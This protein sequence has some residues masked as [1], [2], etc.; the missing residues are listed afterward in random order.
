[1]NAE[2]TRAKIFIP[3]HEIAFKSVVRYRKNSQR[4]WI[5]TSA[6]KWT[7]SALLCIALLRYNVYE[8]DE[9]KDRTS[10]HK[11]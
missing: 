1:M 2:K 3:K 7:K 6:I 4:L 9:G 10:V 11:N 5:E 8:Q